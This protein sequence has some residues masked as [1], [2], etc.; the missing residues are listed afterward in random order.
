MPN[1]STVREFLLLGFSEIRELQLVHAAL[2]LLV[3]LGALTWNLL[4]VAVTTLDRRLHTPMYLFLRHLSVLD[5]C[6]ISVT[7]PKFVVFSL[8]D[9]RSISA[10]GCVV[11][12]FLVV[13]LATSE[14][15]VLTAMSCDRYAAICHPLRHEVIM[16]NTACGKMAA[17]SWLSGVLF[18]VLYTASTFSLRFYGSDIVQQFFCDVPSLL[19]ISCSKDHVAINV[20]FTGGVALSV[21]CFVSIFVRIFQAVLRM[22]AT[23]GRAKAF[24]TCLPHLGVLTV[25]FSTA[26][27]S[28]LKPVS[29]SPSTL[30]LL[31]SVFYTVVPPTLNPLIYSLRNRDLKA[32]LGRVLIG[33]F[34][35]PPLREKI[36]VSFCQYQPVALSKETGAMFGK[37]ISVSAGEQRRA[38]SSSLSIRG[39]RIQ[40]SEEKGGTNPT[41]S[42]CNHDCVHK[43]RES[44]CL[45]GSTL[46]P[47]IH[48]PNPG[49]PGCRKFISFYGYGPQFGLV[50]FFG[51]AEY[52]VLTVMSSDRYAASCA[53]TSSRKK[54]PISCSGN[55]VAIYVSV[56][57]SVALGVVCFVSIVVSYVCIFRVVLRM[58]AAEGRA[59]AF[60]TCLLHLAAVTFF[61][62]TAFISYL[63][64]VSDS[65]SVLDLWC[66]CSSPWC[67]LP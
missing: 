11:Q 16:S 61:L 66:P 9:R 38:D 24:S 23:E 51:G 25:F 62:S 52:F 46:I 36:C 22:P 28:Y 20:S 33:R 30:D 7:L 59:K 39:R 54:R 27:I 19:K 43:Q 17:A 2:F 48:C 31:V 56:T 3:Y 18:G 13:V 53:L 57:S 14:L 65:T 8:T 12:V 4:I 47:S 37:H 45:Y 58:Q 41:Q 64:P 35:L 5:L 42:G 6:L 67:S 44:I 55:H 34:L 29:D 32:A 15:V 63:K 10:L 1:V 21:V 26:V 49:Y 60:T 40:Q 50:V